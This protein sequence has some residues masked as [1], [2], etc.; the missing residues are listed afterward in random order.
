MEEEVECVVLWES[1][2]LVFWPDDK[3]PWPRGSGIMHL[4]SEAAREASLDK[5]DPIAHPGVR[6]GDKFYTLKR[7]FPRVS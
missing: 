4:S 5:C 7:A 2:Y 6:I 1:Q 3:S